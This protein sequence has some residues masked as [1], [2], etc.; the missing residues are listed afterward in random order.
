MV[1]ERS[2][3]VFARARPDVYVAEG[4]FAVLIEYTF[5]EHVLH[6]KR[7]LLPLLLSMFASQTLAK[8]HQTRKSCMH[9]KDMPGSNTMR[10][11]R[12]HIQQSIVFVA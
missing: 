12:A 9:D 2:A 1:L 5:L 4:L 6:G 8:L 11:S 7:D 3:R 10:Y